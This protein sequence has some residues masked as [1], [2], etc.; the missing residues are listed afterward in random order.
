M[1]R[2]LRNTAWLLGG[3][4]FGG[5]C[6]IV[7]LA[8]LS[9]SL[10]LKDFGHF[11]LIFGTA[12]A[13]VAVA[14]FQTW[15]AVVRYG[16]AYVHAN[17]WVRFSRLSMLC[18]V[19]DAAGA[20][21]GCLMAA[22][23]FLGFAGTLDLNPAYVNM[24]FAFNCALM[25]G[26]VSAPTGM[27]R[28]LDRFDAA[29]Y[30]EAMVPVGRLIAASFIWWYG[31]TVGRFLFAWAFVDVTSAFTY[32]AL[33]LRLNPRGFDLAGLRDWRVT[34]SENPQ[35]RRFL[36]IISTASTLD[37][38]FKQGPLLAVGYFLGTSAAGLYRLAD[39]LAQGFGKVST[40]IARAIYP[41]VSR[42]RFASSPTEFRRMIMRIVRIAG[43]G[44]G[45]VV[46]AAIVAGRQLL[47]LIG[48]SA[49]G[50]GAAILVPLAIAASFELA[51][52][53]FEPVLHSTGR[54]QTALFGRLFAVATLAGTILVLHGIGAVGIAW[55]VAVAGAAGYCMLGIMALRT[56][57]R[58]EREETA[59]AALEPGSTEG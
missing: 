51:S 4:G 38:A 5:L 30:V 20:L 59:P 29:V 26:R 2:I 13:L 22:V 58:L 56:L 15:Q 27:M 54:A 52:V 17:D 40:L 21:F 28:A 11:S 31:P 43:I 32:W 12:Q 36:F 37:A 41:E 1:R 3:K 25:W 10:G 9:R 19:I 14:G 55:S 50:A 34:I 57:H 6:S 24:A 33:A 18:G 45:I 23:I 53:A 49:F 39:Q 48:G 16:A 46:L 35:I 8:I 42:A 44:G 7:Y 47:A